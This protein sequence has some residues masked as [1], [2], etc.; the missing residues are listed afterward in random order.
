MGNVTMEESIRETLKMPEV[1]VPE[2]TMLEMLNAQRELDELVY[3]NNNLGTA[4]YNVE[5]NTNT[6][7][8]CLVELG[9]FANEIEFFKH[10][11]KNK[12]DDKDRQLDE[13]ADVLHFVLAL[14]NITK[15][16]VDAKLTFRD[17]Y[18][19]ATQTGVGRPLTLFQNL[20]MVICQD[21]YDLA[22]NLLLHIG[23][24]IG[25]TYEEMEEAYFT[26]RNINFNR[27]KENY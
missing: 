12:R 7:I 21:Q 2:K 5:L 16:T 1:L 22:L 13:F 3:A 19:N 25:F 4:Y 9:E 27:Q 8:A 20:Y 6:K 26:K 15:V 10:W 23:H 11:K 14:L 17:V 24:S 18:N